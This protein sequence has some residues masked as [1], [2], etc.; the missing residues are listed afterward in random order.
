MSPPGTTS[1]D[2]HHLQHHQQEHSF[3]Q[4]HVTSGVLWDPSNP[5]DFTYNLDMADFDAVMAGAT[6]NFWMD[7]PGEASFADPI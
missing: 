4:S 2:G 5:F 6:Q 3:P 7:F 1:A